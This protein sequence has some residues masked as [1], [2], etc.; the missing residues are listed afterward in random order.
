MRTTANIIV[1][2]FTKFARR[3]EYA[4]GEHYISCVVDECLSL[5]NGE[6]V[7][8]GKAHLCTGELPDDISYDFYKSLT[9]TV[10]YSKE[11]AKWV[12]NTSWS[13]E[14]LDEVGHQMSEEIKTEMVECYG[15]LGGEAQAVIDF[16]AEAQEMADNLEFVL[17]VNGLTGAEKLAFVNGWAADGGP[18]DTLGTEWADCTPWALQGA[19]YVSAFE[20]DFLPRTAEEWGRAYW[21]EKKSAI[22]YDRAI[23][24]KGAS[25]IERSMWAKEHPLIADAVERLANGL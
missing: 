24:Y 14:W 13:G 19:I 4:R 15:L 5:E 10:T 22:V 3:G 20:L 7:A 17:Y 12:A 6:L 1:S 8:H 16:D 21:L 18:V 9:V 2:T 25:G 11:R 23:W